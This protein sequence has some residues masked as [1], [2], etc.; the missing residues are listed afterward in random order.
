MR[1]YPVMPLRFYRWGVNMSASIKHVTDATFADDVLNSQTPVAVDFWAPWCGPC[2]MMSPVIEQLAEEFG[3]KLLFAKMN[4]DENPNT[5]SELGIRGIPTL[6]LYVEGKEAE[7]LVG[8]SPKAVLKSKL[9][10]V[11]EA[12][13]AG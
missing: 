12:V 1:E 13:K 4:T 10:A 9:D 6:I 8:F 5:P 2:R 11:L 7:R 3:D